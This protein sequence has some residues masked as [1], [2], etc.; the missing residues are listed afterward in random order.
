V[1]SKLKSWE[2]EVEKNTNEKLNQPLLLKEE[3]G[4][5]KVNFD[6]VLVCLLREV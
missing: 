3:D 4:R 6:A 2:A 1:E 5:L